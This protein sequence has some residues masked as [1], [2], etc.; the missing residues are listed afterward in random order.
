MESWREQY[1]G[2]D[3]LPAS[4]TQA[5]VAFFFKP[6]EQ[7]LPFVETRRRPL[8][9]LGL[10]LHIGFLRMTGRPLAAFDRIPPVILEF[11]ADHAGVPAPQIATLRAI[12]RRRMSLFEH[13]RLAAEAIGWRTAEDGVLRML[14]AFLR[15]QAETEISRPDLVRQA[16]RWLYDRSYILPGERLLERMA[17]IAQDYVLD[18]L[19]SEIEGAVGAEIAPSW[20][21]S[22]SGAKPNGSGV[23]ML[24]WLSGRR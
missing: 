12:Y 8:T 16:R 13:Q 24:D 15:R 22:L 4:L 1:L 11:V 2:V 9:R 3:S 17:A 6:I 20:A 19:K 10:L 18:G 23:S 5:E 7:T 21:A 14:T